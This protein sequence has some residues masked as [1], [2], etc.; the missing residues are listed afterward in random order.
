MHVAPT[1]I[2]SSPGLADPSVTVQRILTMTTSCL[3]TSLY[4]A[5]NLSYFS[6]TDVQ[7]LRFQLTTDDYIVLLSDAYVS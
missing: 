3:I 4:T 2:C 5:I 7:S 1:H 6:L